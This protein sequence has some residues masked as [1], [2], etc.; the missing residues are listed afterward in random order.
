MADSWAIVVAA[1]LG[2][3]ASGG[4]GVLIARLQSQTETVRLRAEAARA[5]AA[6][7]ED[8]RRHREGVYHSF[9]EI[10]YQFR[11][12]ANQVKD[13]PLAAWQG[14]YEH[15]LAGM[16]LFGSAAVR[17]KVLEIEGCVATAIQ[18]SRGPNVQAAKF[19]EAQ[20]A[21]RMSWNDLA[22]AMR[23]ELERSDALT[24]SLRLW[25]RI[26]QCPVAPDLG[27]DRRPPMARPRPRGQGPDHRGVLQ[28]Q[29]EGDGADEVRE[30]PFGSDRPP[31]GARLRGTAWRWPPGRRRAGLPFDP[32]RAVEASPP[33]GLPHPAPA[34]HSL[35]HS[36]AAW[37]LASGLTVHAVAESLGH[38]DPT[39][40]IRRDGHALPA[41]RSGAGE[42][43]E[44][45]LEAAAASDWP[46]IGP[47]APG[48]TRISLLARGSR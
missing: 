33:G 18:T 41:E 24:L 13:F 39:L 16:Y 35:R 8:H 29:D 48:P 45:F 22:K 47:R 20:L 25:P 2:A 36:A 17:D 14:K 4:T 21:L 1:A 31:G 11:N 30:G 5:R 34:I 6:S 28:P 19:Q 32:R 12:R 37:W 38:A 42:R 44:A 23:S 43:L 9:L 10:A 27:P 46:T 3:V 26:Q 7:D 15:L 40:V